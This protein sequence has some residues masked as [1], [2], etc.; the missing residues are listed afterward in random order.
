MILTDSKPRPVRN[1]EEHFG[2]I[3]NMNVGK[4]LLVGSIVLLLA[5]TPLIATAGKND[6]SQPLS[7]SYYETYSL[8]QLNVT[9]QPP[10]YFFFEKKLMDFEFWKVNSYDFDFTEV[11]GVVIL[12]FTVTV[13]HCL[14]MVPTY[15]AKFMFPNNY[16]GT[17]I[18]RL[19]I[20]YPDGGNDTYSVEDVHYTTSSDWVYYTI[21]MTGR[22]LTTNGEN[23]T[24]TFFFWG[25][26]AVTPIPFVQSVVG[27]IK[28]MFRNFLAPDD[29]ITI[30]IHPKPV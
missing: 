20:H 25:G 19:Y 6:I 24:L 3:E 1:R 2:G 15:F 8:G 22:H 18:N 14:N 23:K 17:W 26:P 13:K 27:L 11:N 10:T 7:S 21:N 28:G 16:R 5:T 30:T 12:N 29:H 4:K 9:H